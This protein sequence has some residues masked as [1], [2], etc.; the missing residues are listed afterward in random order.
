MFNIFLSSL[1]IITTVFSNLH[2][3]KNKLQ[4]SILFNT[5]NLIYVHACHFCFGKLH[6]F[7]NLRPDNVL[8]VGKRNPGSIQY[9]CL[10]NISFPMRFIRSLIFDMAKLISNIINI[11]LGTNTVLII[12]QVFSHRLLLLTIVFDKGLQI[13][14]LFMMNVSS[15]VS[16]MI[17]YSFMRMSEFKIKG[18]FW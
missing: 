16:F 4:L 1:T 15:T 8:M 13:I 12:L 14:L 7:F 18:L 17:D 2:W 9:A 5:F 3:Y 11:Q 10:N 6:L